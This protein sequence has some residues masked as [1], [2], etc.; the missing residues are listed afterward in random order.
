MRAFLLL[1]LLAVTRCFAGLDH[2]VERDDSGIWSRKYQNALRYGSLAADF[3]L[4]LYEGS[5]T[6][7]G[8]ASWQSVDSVVLSGLAAETGK[9]VF[10]RQRPR[11]TDNSN[12]WFKGGKSF[13]SGEVAEISGIVTPYVLEYRRDQPLVYA[14]E[15][16]PVYDAIARVKSQAHWQTDVIAGFAIGTISGYWAH[17]RSVPVTVDLLPHGITLGI[18]SRF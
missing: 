8:K 7:L 12:E 10:G 16:L 17:E 4:A 11:D 1:S 13:P 14:L 9:R 5:E 15:A 6:R 18:K 2:K 3:G